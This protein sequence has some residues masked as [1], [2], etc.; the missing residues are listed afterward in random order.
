M[1]KRGTRQGGN[2]GN[3]GGG[4]RFPNQNN[5]GGASG[6]HHGAGGGPDHRWNNGS[7]IVFADN[8]GGY[9]GNNPGAIGG[10]Y[11]GNNPGFV[12]GCYK[13]KN[14]KPQFAN[15][16]ANNPVANGGVYQGENPGFVPGG[17]KGKNP[18]PQFA[19]NN[20][21]GFN[22]PGPGSVN[23]GHNNPHRNKDAWYPGLHIDDLD[24]PTKEHLELIAVASGL[25]QASDASRRDYA[26][27]V[28]IKA[29]WPP[30][31]AMWNMIQDIGTVDPSLVC[32]IHSAGVQRDADGDVIMRDADAC[33]CL[34]DDWNIPGCL[35][36]AFFYMVALAK[37]NRLKRQAQQQQQPL[38]HQ[39]QK[40]PWVQQQQQKQQPVAS[41]ATATRLGSAAAAAAV[42]PAAAAAAGAA[43]AG[44]LMGGGVRAWG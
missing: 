40:Q 17:Y 35:K 24:D 33:D 30:E 38:R 6:G 31:S 29:Q 19:N 1:G 21:N 2:G 28:A 10:V 37:R 34:S 42:G 8:A 23:R 7:G 26:Q 15:N 11:Q 41:A 44:A 27:E 18:K 3:G 13:G 32:F 5:N 9:K 36:L 12:P 43:G 4:G 22:G 14:P 25:M 39:Q 16:N 20:A